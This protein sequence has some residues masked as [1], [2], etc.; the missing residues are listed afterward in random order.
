MRHI[1]RN[2][3]RNI[4][5]ENMHLTAIYILI[6]CALSLYGIKH[7][8]DLYRKGILLEKI[9]KAARRALRFALK[10]IAAVGLAWLALSAFPVVSD[11]GFA[12]LPTDVIDSVRLLLQAVFETNSVYAAI[13]I[14]AGIAL[15]AVEFSLLFSIIGLFVIKECVIPQLLNYTRRHGGA[16]ARW[17]AE[18]KIPR[19]FRKIFLNFAN[20]RI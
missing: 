17:N 18:V 7:V 8:Q 5:G 10:G 9:E 6:L 13:Q 20:L 11:I 15:F 3:T 19:A 14:F 12:M 2:R 16:E 4:L 1:M